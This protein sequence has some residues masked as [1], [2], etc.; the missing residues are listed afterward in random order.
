VKAFVQFY[1]EHVGKLVSVV[2]YVPLADEVAEKT[3]RVL[4]EALQGVR[5]AA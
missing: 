2:G 3:K 1:L 5:P 4:E